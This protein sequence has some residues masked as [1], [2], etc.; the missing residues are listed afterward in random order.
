M[1][2]GEPRAILLDANVFVA[3]I[4][5]PS[6]ETHTYRLM[7]H[8]LEQGRVRLVGNILLA[9]EYVRYAEAF[10]SP[11]AAA[12]AAA[13]VRGMDI[14]QVED[15]FVLACSPHFPEGKMADC[16]HAATCLQ[17]DAVLVSNDRDFKS[18]ADAGLIRRWTVADAIRRL[19]PSSDR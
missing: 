4:K 11:T 3:A 9:Q 5:R 15:R 18:V 10:P 12:L 17:T 1:P 7:V 8:L 13:L 2:E 16:V 19:L 14:V 6:R